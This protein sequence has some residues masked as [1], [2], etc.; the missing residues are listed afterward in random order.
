MEK[1]TPHTRLHLVQAMVAEGKV[2]ATRSA[3]DSADELNLDFDG[4]CAVIVA[5]TRQDFYKSMTTYHD[6]TV[7]QD[8][9]RPMI[10]GI[11]FY[12]K[13]TVLDDVLIVSFKEK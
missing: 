11:R 13:V 9:Y 1:K 10:K 5:L 8:V 3:L 12:M 7:W 6:H 2:R 4:M